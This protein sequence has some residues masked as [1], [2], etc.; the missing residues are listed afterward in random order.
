[1]EGEWQRLS[2]PKHE[3]L[4]P[5]LYKFNTA[6]K[7]YEIYITDLTQLWREQLSYKQV[8]KRAEEDNTTVDPGEDPEQFKVLLQKINA[9]LCSSPGS[10]M[11]L[12]PGSG[13]KTDSLHLQLSIKLPAPLK[14][15]KWNVYLS[16]EPYTASTNHLLLPLMRAEKNWEA[17]QQTLLEHLKQKD[18]VLAKLF[19]KIEAM[20]IDLSTIFP[21]TS[22]LRGTRNETS[23]A[24]AAKYIKGV[25]PFN[26]QAWLN[27]N[28][29]PSEPGVAASL[30]TAI[31]GSGP[32]E[33]GLEGLSA[34]PDK[35]WESLDASC[36]IGVTPQP[37]GSE[38]EEPV[39][40]KELGDTNQMDIDTA[41]EDEDDE[42]EVRT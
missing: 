33:S 13:S 38:E 26:E 6:S 14:P 40:T 18:W 25:A 15:L 3:G 23:L 24:Q 28:Q 2:L 5:L 20:G 10:S 35:W 9:A 27:H 8:L 7:S 37:E 11:A 29:E 42:F 12:T 30:L 39:T 31:S 19:D 34:P 22:G 21:G 41:S 1:M 17:R 4:P 32:D 16:R 36:T